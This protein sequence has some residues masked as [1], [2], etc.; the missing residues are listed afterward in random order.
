M[1][2]RR[3]LIQCNVLNA[4]Q[5]WALDTLLQELSAAPVGQPCA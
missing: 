2:K 1:M 4:Q 3:G 5:I